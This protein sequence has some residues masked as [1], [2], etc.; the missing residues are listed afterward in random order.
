M[1]TFSYKSAVRIL[2]AI[3]IC[4]KP[5]GIGFENIPRNEPVIFVYNHIVLRVE[6]VWLALG[7]PRDLHIRFFS[8]I[9]LAD[10]KTISILKKDIRDSVFTQK[11]QK[12]ATRFRWT[13]AALEKCVNSM[14][15]YIIAQTNR[16][17]VIIANLDYPADKEEISSK[18]KTN[19]NALKKCVRCLENDI[20][21]AIAPSGGKTYEAF[22]NPVYNTTIPALASRL[23]NK[24]KVVKIVPS[25]I[26][27]RPTINQET[28]WRYVTNRIIFYR[29]FRRALH[30]FRIKSYKK[31]TLTI[32][33]LPPLTFEKANPS[34]SEK[35]DFVKNLLQLIYDN[36]KN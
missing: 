19:L 30:L 22:E 27:E 16:F 4:P 24:G 2:R 11:F 29:I 26:K 20:P 35:V 12:K 3:P 9:K 15:W 18:F 21:I 23:Y 34:K 28:Y 7:A 32:E 6:P 1:L 13:K 14:A 31:P 17:D 36:L 5:K 33:F 8:D 25:I 10:P